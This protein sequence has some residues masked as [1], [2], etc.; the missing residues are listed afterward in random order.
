ME[1]CA[2]GLLAQLASAEE[3]GR[4][5]GAVGSRA[6]A[7]QFWPSAAL[8]HSS[9]NPRGKKQRER[10]VLDILGRS[11]HCLT[12][13]VLLEHLCN[14]ILRTEHRLQVLAKSLDLSQKAEK[15]WV[16]GILNWRQKAGCLAGLWAP[17]LMEI[18]L[19]S[20]GRWDH[21]LLFEFSFPF[22]VNS[23]LSGF[24]LIFQVRNFY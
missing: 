24:C 13:F 1:V 14:E 23:C 6:A 18:L 21:S 17:F 22:Q 3:W 4:K 2:P 10:K 12:A 7:P 8:S 16:C 11:A 19:I 5:K 15:P 9:L 20:P